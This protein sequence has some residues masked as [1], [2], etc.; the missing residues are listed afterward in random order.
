M[1]EAVEWVGMLALESKSPASNPTFHAS[2][3]LSV[4]WE[5][6]IVLIFK[7]RYEDQNE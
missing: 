3:V 7:S 2:V 5:R 1:G 4:K 6:K